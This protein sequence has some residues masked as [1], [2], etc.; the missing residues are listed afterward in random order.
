M[1][2]VEPR[3]FMADLRRARMCSGGA[4]DFFARHDLDWDDFLRNGVPVD[5]VEATG[6][7]MALKVV[8]VV[9]GQR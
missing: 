8:E 6:D 2:K 5:R 3:I 9:R 7:A 1:T 4:R